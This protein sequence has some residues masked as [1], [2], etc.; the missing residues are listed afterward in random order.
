ME[1]DDD[2][3][4]ARKHLLLSKEYKDHPES[5]QKFVDHTKSCSTNLQPTLG[6]I[7]SWGGGDLL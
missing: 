6:V 5:K 2:V 1:Q 4:D 7:E 3:W